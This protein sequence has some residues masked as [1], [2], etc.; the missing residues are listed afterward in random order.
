MLTKDSKLRGLVPVVVERE[1]RSD[2]RGGRVAEELVAK[3][4]GGRSTGASDRRGRRL[5]QVHRASFCYV[6]EAGERLGGKQG[7]DFQRKLW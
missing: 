6:G 5:D 4:D 7:R 1:H 2:H 3:I